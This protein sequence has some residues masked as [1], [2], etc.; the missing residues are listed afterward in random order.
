MSEAHVYKIHAP[1]PRKGLPSQGSKGFFWPN[2][3]RQGPRHAVY[4]VT[5]DGVRVDSFLRRANAVRAVKAMRSHEA[6]G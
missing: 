3:G 2:V 6:A 1:A 4:L 5:R